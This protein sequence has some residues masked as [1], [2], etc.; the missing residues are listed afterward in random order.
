MLVQVEPTDFLRNRLTLDHGKSLEKEKKTSW[1]RNRRRRRRRCRLRHIKASRAA[2]PLTASLF[3]VL[4][5]CQK[6]YSSRYSE[7]HTC[8][9]VV[10]NTVCRVKQFSLPVN[11]NAE[12]LFLTV[13]SI[14]F[15]SFCFLTVKK[16]WTEKLL[17]VNNITFL[18]IYC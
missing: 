15:H 4:S 16:T 8:G 10:S 13:L 6:R 17:L 5:A 11:A 3:V 14:L 9:S 7:G 2:F 18:S 1:S 12:G